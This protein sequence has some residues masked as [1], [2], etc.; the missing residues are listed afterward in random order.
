MALVMSAGF[1]FVFAADPS[2]PDLL[3]QNLDALYP[4]DNN[5]LPIEGSPTYDMATHTISFT[6]GWS[7]MGWSFWGADLEA[8]IAEYQTCTIEFDAVDYPMLAAISNWRTGEGE[9]SRVEIPAGTTKAVL[10][11]T[12]PSTT[13]VLQCETD[14]GSFPKTVKLN[15]AYLSKAG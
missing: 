1:S 13:I 12:K 14:Q 8:K 9:I 4:S 15:A 6:T 5:G 11:I 10:N 2:N 3:S 7:N